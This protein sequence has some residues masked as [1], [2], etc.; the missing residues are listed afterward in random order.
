MSRRGLQAV[1]TGIGS[2]A[3]VAGVLGVVGGGATVLEGGRVSANV[4]SEFRFHATWYAVLGV[5]MLRAAR[6]PEHETVVIR[7]AGAGFL[8]AACSRVVS[9]A[10]VG[11]PHWW[12]RLLMALE[13][14]MPAVIIPWQHRLARDTTRRS[15]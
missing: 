4:D 13:F 1:I 3:T 15:S 9:W 6:R 8:V 11:K 7:A 2:V 12:F 5:L 10:W 14:V